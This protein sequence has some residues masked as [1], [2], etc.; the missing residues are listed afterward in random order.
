MNIQTLNEEQRKKLISLSEIFFPELQE[1]AKKETIKWCNE[2]NLNIDEENWGFRLSN[3][4]HN[5][6]I[7]CSYPID[8]DFHIHLIPNN[9]NPGIHWYQFCLEKLSQRMYDTLN[10]EDDS[11]ECYELSYLLEIFNNKVKEH[12]VDYLYDLYKENKKYF[13]K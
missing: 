1:K 4:K 2:E 8:H 3:Q 9:F 13:K 6:L 10:D 11:E 12:P 5:T 7:Y